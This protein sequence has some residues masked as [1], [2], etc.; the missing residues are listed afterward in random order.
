MRWTWIW[1]AVL[2][3]AGAAAA[4]RVP[5]TVDFGGIEP[6]RP[7][8]VKGGVPFARG[9]LKSADN[10]RLLEG[11]IEVPLQVRALATWPDG[12]VKWILLDFA[13]SANRSYCLEF[14]AGVTRA[15]PA[16]QSVRVAPYAVD[17][18]PFPLIPPHDFRS[19][20]VDTG[21]V[22]FSVR[23]GGSGFIDEL[24][25]DTNGDGKYSDDE[26]IVADEK[27]DGPR[28][29]GQSPFSSQRNFLNYV[30]VERPED[31][32]A[33]SR[34][35]KG[36]LDR[37]RVR[38]E[39]IAVEEPGPLRASIR[40]RGCYLYDLVGSTAPYPPRRENQF[41]VRIHAWRGS[42]LIRAEH[43]FVFE[44]DP[45]RDFVRAMGLALDSKALASP[46]GGVDALYQS[47]SDTY[48]FYQA[49]A[50]KVESAEHWRGAAGTLGA[51]AST[52][53]L[54]AGIRHMR[55][56]Y[57]KG[58]RADRDT[59][60][61]VAY[62]YPP[63]ARP[64]DLRRYARREYGVGET[65]AL[66]TEPGREYPELA[67][68][69]RSC[70][71]GVGR[72][73]DVFF[74]FH[75]KG[76]ER[77]AAEALR[78]ADRGAVVRAPIDAIAKT[79]ALGDYATFAEGPCA[80][81]WKAALKSLD[82]S[83]DARERFRWFGFFDFGDQ[84]T[85]FN[86]QRAGRW[87][88]DWGR[89]GWGNNDGVG[90]PSEAFAMAYLA[91]GT[92]EYFDALEASA[93]HSAEVDVLHTDTA[94]GTV[95]RVRGLSHRHGVQ[96]WSDP[97]VGLRGSNCAGWRVY[98]YLTGEERLRDV[99]DEVADAAMADRYGS[100]APAG[101]FEGGGSA[102]TALLTMWEITADAKYRDAIKRLMETMPAPA[103]AWAAGQSVSSGFL[104]AAADFHALANDAKAREH[105]VRAADATL[106]YVPRPGQSW[107]FSQVRAL[108]EAWRLT[109][110]NRYRRHA[111]KLL[112]E[113]GPA[114]VSDPRVRLERDQWPGG[115]FDFQVENTEF[116][117][118]LALPFALRLVEG[119][120]P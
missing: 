87:E 117:N 35:A 115:G 62:L 24:W 16:G 53:G 80:E 17:E 42:G 85:R 43:S 112:D 44:G 46:A 71:R 36:A 98:Y 64:L 114:I 61:V 57:P 56:L 75:R 96:H 6:T 81:V 119:D 84:Q 120:R 50:G 38:V 26:R 34:F 82:W 118:I 110:E 63:D 90:R 9:A 91:T 41:T 74:A 2:V 55:E 93:R 97:Y 39:E 88:N 111:L 7:A 94:V 29:A 77:S 54:V 23:K 32:P 30:H 4:E 12:S 1:A 10:V 27:G 67:A 58:L 49:K 11:G 92:R 116:R 59:G 109:G 70:S 106:G 113:Y 65:G 19:V 5:L 101:S 47:S 25:L 33:D 40:V 78:V 89:W 8:F 102:A 100:S 103:N 15:A 51:S 95:D 21:V 72:S 108:A 28:T 45:D 107:P 69:S 48:D 104:A 66:D 37:S 99:L 105:V 14:G 68:F 83:L 18:A 3:L 52:W 86:F 31:F 76:E 22:K 79:R 13:A 20:E 60:R 73:H